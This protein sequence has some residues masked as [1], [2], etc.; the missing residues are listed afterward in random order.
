MPIAQLDYEEMIEQEET[1]EQQ[2]QE[3]AAT[4]EKFD[5]IQARARMAGAL[6]QRAVL[7]V[8][9]KGVVG[10]E[11]DDLSLLGFFAQLFTAPTKVSLFPTPFGAF[12]NLLQGQGEPWK[13]AAKSFIDLFTWPKIIPTLVVLGKILLWISALLLVVF[14]IA[15]AEECYESIAGTGGEWS[16]C[17]AAYEILKDV[18]KDFFDYVMSQLGSV[19][20]VTPHI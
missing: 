14:L 19:N 15:L 5:G 4:Q 7:N 10:G 1:E 3:E 12:F 18:F 17:M 16:S 9:G 20:N 11:D 13:I 2:R 6:A 8:G